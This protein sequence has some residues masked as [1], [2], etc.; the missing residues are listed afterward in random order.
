MHLSKIAIKIQTLKSEIPASVK[1]IAVS[2]TQPASRIVEAYEAGLTEFGENYVQEAL[3]KLKLLKAYPI[4][5]HFIGAIQSNKTEE[6]AENFSWVHS[7]SREKI[8]VR[9]NE[10]RPIELPPLNV[11]LQINISEEK[12]KSGLRPDLPTILTLA[13]IIKNLPRLHL[14]G[15]MAIPTEE[16]EEQKTRATFKKLRRLFEALN[17][18]GFKMDMLS[19]GMSGDFKWAIAEGSTCV[20]LGTAIFGLRK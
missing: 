8:A 17:Q 11:C 19:M 14:R 15:L 4:Q 1:I 6:I 18:E 9:L 13:H 3:I 20:R 10:A 12:T 16:S 5:W 7:I 2:K